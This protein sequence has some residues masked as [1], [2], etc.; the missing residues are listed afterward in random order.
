MHPP[1]NDAGTALL[2]GVRAI[3]GA[4]GRF[5]LEEMTSRGWASVTFT[6]A[7]HQI[8]FRIEGEQAEAAAERL[9]AGLEA[10]EFTLRGHILAD[11]VLVSQERRPGC[12]RIAL[13]ALTVEDA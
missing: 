1:L 2:R 8:A 6:G 13:E 7:R 5:V 12:A 3:A 4:S 10:A 9:L 11:I